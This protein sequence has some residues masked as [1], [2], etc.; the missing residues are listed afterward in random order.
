MSPLYEFVI[1]VYVII[2]KKD[3]TNHDDKLCLHKNRLKHEIV[4]NFF[5]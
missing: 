2:G 1:A 4:F 3:N 5:W